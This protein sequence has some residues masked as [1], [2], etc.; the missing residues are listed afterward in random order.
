MCCR[1]PAPAGGGAGRG[2]LRDALHA[3]GRWVHDALANA[4]TFGLGWIAAVAALLVFHFQDFGD[5]LLRGAQGKTWG[6]IVR[7]SGA[8]TLHG[9]YRPVPRATKVLLFASCLE[10][11]ALTY[12]VAGVPQY[13]LS[14]APEISPGD[15]GV[16]EHLLFG[17][18]GPRPDCPF[19]EGARVERKF[20]RSDVQP[21][22]ARKTKVCRWWALTAEFEVVNLQAIVTYDLVWKAIG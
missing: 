4:S 7:A 22:V 2:F 21:H 1:G 13:V 14:R 6:V 18:A 16:L 20:T 3:L 17:L 19:V 15:E 10:G 5:G 8:A 12:A 9:P 11:R